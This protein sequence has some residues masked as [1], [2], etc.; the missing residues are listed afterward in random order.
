MSEDLDICLLRIGEGSLHYSHLLS[1]VGVLPPS[2]CPFPGERVSP[3]RRVK[4]RGIPISPNLLGYCSYVKKPECSAFPSGDEWPCGV[5]GDQPPNT[6]GFFHRRSPVLPH[7]VLHLCFSQ[8]VILSRGFLGLG[9]G[10][11]LGYPKGSKSWTNKLSGKFM[12]R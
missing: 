3:P 2:L 9:L 6:N 1:S 5:G 7:G 10:S 12:T 8:K 11:S 4:V